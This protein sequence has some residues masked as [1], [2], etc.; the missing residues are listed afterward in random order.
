MLSAR[1]SLS[2]SVFPTT[3]AGHKKFNSRLVTPTLFRNKPFGDHV[4]GL[5]Y[6][7]DESYRTQSMFNGTVLMH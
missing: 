4:E 2:Q 7:E 5:S 6:C 1:Q 3:H